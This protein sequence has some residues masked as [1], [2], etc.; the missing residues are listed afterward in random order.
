MWLFLLLAISALVTS[1]VG[2]TF[3]WSGEGLF[4]SFGLLTDPDEIPLIFTQLWGQLFAPLLFCAIS[5]AA[6]WGIVVLATIALNFCCRGSQTLPKL[7]T[8][9]VIGF[10]LS[11]AVTLG[12]IAIALFSLLSLTPP[13]LFGAPW[14]VGAILFAASVAC[15]LAACTASIMRS[16]AQ[17][18]APFAPQLV[19]PPAP[20][21][22]RLAKPG[23]ALDA[24][25]YW[26]EQNIMAR[27]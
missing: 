6:L 8:A 10:L 16:P 4:I 13:G 3:P 18:G 23:E 25:P 19:P 24:L 14:G 22:A 27:A 1:S 5:S 7:R 2:I 9:R 17:P 21:L 11:A 15:G 20:P 12:C 26:Q